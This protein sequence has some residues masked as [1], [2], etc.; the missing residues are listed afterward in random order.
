M[1]LILQKMLISLLRYGL[2]I[3]TWQL[4]SLPLVMA[5]NAGTVSGQVA[6]ADGQALPGVNVLL[7][8][9]SNAGTITSQEG[10]Y[11]LEVPT[12]DAV[13]VFSFIG[14]VTQEVAVEGKSE[15]DVTLQ[16]DVR[17]LNEVVVVG[18]GTQQRSDLTG[19]IGSVE[20]ESFN[21]GVMVSPEQ[22]IQGKV[23]G[24]N[25]TGNTGQPGSAQTIIIRGPGSIRSGN[26]PLFVVDGV[27]LDNGSTS[28]S[29]PNVGFGSSAPLNPLAFLNP[30]DIKSIDVL[31]DASATAIYGSRGANGVVI[32]TT[33]KGASQQDGLTY[34]T[35]FG[36]AN[37][38]NKIDVLEADAFIRFQEQNGKAEN[39]YD[40]NLNTDWQ[41]EIFRTAYS[42]QHQL[43]LNGSSETSDYYVSLGYLEQEGL[44]K[45]NELDRY[46]GRF[47]FQ[48]RLLDDRLNISLNLTASHI[49][50]NGSPRN[51][52]ADAN[53]GSLLPDALGANPTYPVYNDDGT[54]FRFPNGRNPLADLSLYTDLTRTDRVLGNIEGSL[55][56]IK[57][58]EYRI[59]VGIDRST[60]KR[61]TQISR[62]GLPNIQ[63]PE[64]RVV[65]NYTE[66]TNRLIENYLKYTF[67]IANHSIEAL[68]GHS[69]QRFY[70][71]ANGSSINNFSTEEI[72][73]IYN[74]GIGTSLDINQ[75][76]PYGSA[77][78]NELQSFFG[79]VNYGYANKY[80]LTATLRADGS[81][82]FGANNKYGIFPSVS[83]AWKV[84]EEDFLSGA[85]LLSELKLRVG[86]GQTGN[87]E[88]PGKIT[89]PSL[90]SSDDS[91][92][93]GYPLSEDGVTPGY[94]YVR[95]AN[96]DIRWEVTTQTNVGLDYGLLEGR[97]YGSID[98]FY[99]NT[100]DM[101]LE[102]TV[103]D[104]VSP[105]GTRWGN[106]DMN[107]INEGLEM[108]LNYT[109]KATNDFY[110]RVGGNATFLRNEV[111]NAPFTF[112][113]TGDVRGPGLSGVTASGNL[114]GEPISTFYLL[115]HIGFDENGENVFRDVNKDSTINADDRI[116]AGSPIPNFTYN[117]YGNV[118]YKNFSLSL[119]FNGISGNKIYNNTANAYF[120][121]PQ[122]ASGLNVASNVVNPSESF[123]NSATA[124]TRFLENGSFL[125]LNNATLQYNID[126][127]AIN[128]LREL[129]VYVTGQNLFTLT[130]YTGFDPEVNVPSGVG[131]ITAY[132]IDFTGYPRARTFLLGLN[133]SF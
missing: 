125:R 73:A 132:G 112:L 94:I 76:R 47:N 86:W 24:V 7:K 10:R 12:E 6:D 15:I 60:G 39:I 99:K 1:P 56:L 8:A 105:T 11:S 28:P 23:S 89:Q 58:L 100:S 126:L 26:E 16:T 63:Y 68:A 110:W 101:L 84:N 37:A 117:F 35:Y 127:T 122:L 97:I 123:T 4:L 95:T 62:S 87:Q 34:S 119:N 113:R 65:F 2:F 70:Q 59:N 45:T 130:D 13:L 104:P 82:K 85:N 109:S 54:L 25:I 21:D 43:A 81:S 17:Q 102:L 121:L 3:M 107:V 64:G 33:K 115:D 48:Q 108:A 114:N 131:G 38:A 55:Q 103:S 30:N 29:A 9:S 27:P 20:E 71:R 80:L 124:S 133:V 69:Y 91:R 116:A 42:Q 53:F 74:P 67:D 78:I 51:D 19:A 22:L 44:I 92:G 93:T 18:Y 129:S 88:I 111:R 49:D 57:G 83:G 120:N 31:K 106:V 75:N 98:Y 90:I 32:I 41:D 36:I 118:S 14:Y 96:P 40:R 52:N 61:D 79:R 50:N 5:Q 46:T 72:D 66:S 77:N 128:W